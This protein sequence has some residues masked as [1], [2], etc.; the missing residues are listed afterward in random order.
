MRFSGY[1][2]SCRICWPTAR[3][4]LMSWFAV[5]PVGAL[6]CVTTLSLLTWGL[7][8]AGRSA[9]TEMDTIAGQLALQLQVLFIIRQN[10]TINS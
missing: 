6:V 2:S 8:A 7:M 3:K 10:I 9:C 5:R 1:R 4:P